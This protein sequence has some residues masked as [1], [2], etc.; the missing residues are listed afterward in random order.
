MSKISNEVKWIKI[1]VNIFDDEKIKLID[2]M[3]DCDSVLVIWFKLLTLAGKSNNS[4]LLFFKDRLPYT[5]EMLSTIFNRKL[6]TV[7]YALMI[8]RQFGMIDIEENVVSITNW[9]K[10]QNI[11]GL[12]KIREQNR[13]RA[14][15]FRENQKNKLLLKDKNIDTDK[16]LDIDIENNVTETLSF[17]QKLEIINNVFIRSYGNTKAPIIL[18]E[19]LPYFDKFGETKLIKLLKDGAMNNFKNLNNLI[20]KINWETGE[21]N[22]DNKQEVKQESAAERVKRIFGD[23]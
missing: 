22:L 14:D 21:L 23:D 13:I 4:G 15:R 3:P 11:D 7:R 20:S 8:F 12:D 9:E 6:E 17:E 18:E 1:T 10:H 16:D 19:F 5:E 2:A